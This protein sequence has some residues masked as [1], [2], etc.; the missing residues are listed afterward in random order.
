MSEWTTVYE[1][2]IEG[3]PVTVKVYRSDQAA[4]DDGDEGPAIRVTTTSIEGAPSALEEDKDGD[5]LL[6]EREATAR[7]ITLEPY[8]V[9]DLEGELMEL[10]F[11]P[12]AAAQIASK[13]PV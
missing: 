10:G 7:L 2:E 13:I 6:V 1:D 11:S 4:E 5:A 12:E 3:R 9:E 8:G